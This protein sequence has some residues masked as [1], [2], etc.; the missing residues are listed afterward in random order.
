M[1]PEAIFVKTK[2]SRPTTPCGL[3]LLF[4]AAEHSKGKAPAVSDYSTTSLS[5]VSAEAVAPT[6]AYTA[7][8]FFP[9]VLMDILNNKRF[10]PIISWKADGKSFVIISRNEFEEKVLP[11]YFESNFD[12]FL[13]KLKR[14]GFQ[15][16]KT[17]LQGVTSMEFSQKDFR[18]DERLLCL[19]MRCNSEKRAT[20]RPTSLIDPPNEKKKVTT[21]SSSPISYQKDALVDHLLNQQ[22]IHKRLLDE[23]KATIAEKMAEQ[24]PQFINKREFLLKKQL[25]DDATKTVQMARRLSQSMASP[26]SQIGRIDRHR[27]FTQLLR[28]SKIL[29]ANARSEDILTRYHCPSSGNLRT[30]HSREALRRAILT[31]RQGVVDPTAEN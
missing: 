30:R 2:G 3:D 27:H 11:A 25:I 8:M 6:C 9:E 13:R 16:E 7:K 19:R 26:L 29:D 21:P 18:R 20:P 31:T 23:V 14:W 15:R 24:R 12:S 22:A 4:A 5:S 28:L 1:L 17:R 10:A